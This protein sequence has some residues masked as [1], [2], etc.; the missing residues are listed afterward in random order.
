VNI[1]DFQ[2]K[3]ILNHPNAIET[4]QKKVFEPFLMVGSDQLIPSYAWDQIP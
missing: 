3:A 4:W 2:K 1:V